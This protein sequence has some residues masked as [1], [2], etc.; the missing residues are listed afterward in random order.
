ML[1]TWRMGDAVAL[2]DWDDQH[3]RGAGG[4]FVPAAGGTTPEKVVEPSAGPQAAAARAS[5]AAQQASHKAQQDSTVD[6]HREAA[7]LHAAAAV[8]SHAAA[9]GSRLLGTLYKTK[10]DGHW[11]KATLHGRIADAKA[12]G[13]PIFK[14]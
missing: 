9:R 6:N 3:P 12:K 7:R 13:Q 10:A 8:A 5:T 14:G 2:A 1:M 11:A 4:K